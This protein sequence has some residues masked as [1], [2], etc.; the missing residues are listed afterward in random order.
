MNKQFA[1]IALASL[2]VNVSFAPNAEAAED[3][4]N[5]LV[6][7]VEE[8]H[9]MGGNYKQAEAMAE[10]ALSI[11]RQDKTGLRLPTAID[12]V[13][14]CYTERGR[15]A[16]AQALLE[17]ALAARLQ[18]MPESDPEVISTQAKLAR[19]MHFRGQ[20]KQ[21]QQII[22]ELIP[23]V[24]KAAGQSNFDSERTTV[25]KLLGS[26]CDQQE[27]YVEAEQHYKKALD[28]IRTRW[29]PN[30]TDTALSM[31]DLAQVYAHQN[32]YVDAET[33]LRA[34]L[35]IY[36][37]EVPAPY[38]INTKM[39]L[40][41]A[42]VYVL[43]GRYKEAEPL[44]KEAVAQDEARHMN[45]DDLVTSLN[46]LGLFYFDRGQL[47][48]AQ[49]PLERALE[50]QQKRYG[51][52]SV[53]LVR[54]L[55]LNGM[56]NQK[57]KQ[58]QTAEQF[59]DRAYKITTTDMLPEHVSYRKIL[60]RQT[61]LYS[62]ENKWS[63][64]YKFCD[65]MLKRDEKVLGAEHATVAADLDQLAVIAGK[66][67]DDKQSKAL[68]DKADAIKVKLKGFVRDDKPVVG[69]VE[70]RS[71]KQL[72]DKWA[73]IIGLSNFKNQALNLKFGAKDARD[74]AAFLQDKAGFPADHI[75]V[76]IDDQATREQ[77]VDHLSDKWL[78]KAGKD[79]LVV[80]YVSSHGTSASSE[81][82]GTSFIV[83]YDGDFNNI[84]TTGIPLEWLQK[85]ASRQVKADR[86]VLLLD[87]CH[88]GAATSA[89]TTSK[90]HAGQSQSVLC[91][92][93]PSQVSWESLR[94]PNSVFTHWLIEN[95]GKGTHLGTGFANMRA[96]VEREVL[97]D[98]QQM[99]TPVM[100]QLWDGDQLSLCK[101]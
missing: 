16:K 36:E 79:D 64:A 26:L 15:Y 91:S 40:Q 54:A 62:E 12:N 30:A 19:M 58:Y 61:D 66:L 90:A 46:D 96:A 98:R 24:I 93:E 97:E 38:N 65:A 27:L 32:R 100:S 13:V 21:A 84:L 86:M 33:L 76:L 22:E 7:R 75:A 57:R 77:I 23:K 52:D 2:I 85:L 20:S 29:G 68:K 59:F 51:P 78:G 73:L 39:M 55:T 1:F 31:Q 10:K 34:A 6:S 5:N 67:G 87:V 50:L 4:F 83:P 3:E 53:K 101:P 74:F 60:S 88:S 94:Y 25:H 41:L 9:L 35:K 17:E 44:L 69:Q 99:Q 28:L 47:D 56:L 11:A 80:V 82:M 95:L 43:Q 14:D 81:N 48:K 37:K 70:K 89:S 45:N 71:D 49:E 18:T 8:I 42:N 92:S 63:Q 72:G